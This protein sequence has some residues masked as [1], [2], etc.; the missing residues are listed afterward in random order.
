MRS[1]LRILKGIYD[2]LASY[3]LLWVLGLALVAWSIHA[4]VS[5]SLMPFEIDGPAAFWRL[6]R[7]SL[8]IDT[9]ALRIVFFGALHVTLFWAFRSWIRRLVRSVDRRIDAVIFRYQRFAER[10]R[11]LATITSV[12]F[13]LLVTALLIPFV[14][15]PTLVPAR[16]DSRAWSQRLANLLDGQASAAIA[17]SVIGLYRRWLGAKP[18]VGPRVVSGEAKDERRAMIDRWDP[19]IGAI[20]P[21]ADRAAQLKALMVV[22]SGGEQ[23]AVSRTGCIGLMQFCSRTAQSRPFRAIFGSGTVYPCRCEG[24]CRVE[25]SVR[26]ALESGSLEQVLAQQSAYPC[27]LSDGR[28]DPQRALRAGY[29]YLEQLA[30]QLDDNLLLIYIGYNSGPLVARAIQRSLGSAAKS[31]DTVAI[32]PYLAAALHPTFGERAQAR[33]RGLLRI[34]LPKLQRAYRHYRSQFAR[35]ARSNRHGADQH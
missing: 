12:A 31:A 20:A 9:V 16:N 17:E 25:R 11:R 5:L 21:T 6:V 19:L 30:G 3:L 15:Q 23:F 34:H 18:I 29:A 28:L 26:S 24:P 4:I 13:S 22:E 7:R 2:L 35:G 8:A 27:E 33:A 32:A 14:V 1:L 10:R